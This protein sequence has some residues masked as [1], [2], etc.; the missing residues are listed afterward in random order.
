LFLEDSLIR[1][2]KFAAEL[3]AE[4]EKKN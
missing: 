1:I 4:A 3:A 2:R